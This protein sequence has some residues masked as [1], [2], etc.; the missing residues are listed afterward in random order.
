[1]RNNGFLNELSIWDIGIV[2]KLCFHVSHLLK[3]K[4][5]QLFFGFLKEQQKAKTKHKTVAKSK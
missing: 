4:L 5:L 2:T 3:A 1:M